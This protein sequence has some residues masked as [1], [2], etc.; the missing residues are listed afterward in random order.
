METKT[1]IKVFLSGPSDVLEDKNFIKSFIND[2]SQNDIGYQ[3]IDQGD[4]PSHINGLPAQ[5][6]I[7]SYLDEQKIDIYIG[8]MGTKFGT[9]TKE[10]GSGT[11]E[12]FTIFFE[13]YQRTN[14]PYLAFM[15]KETKVSIDDDVEAFLN[16]KNF[17]KKIENIGLYQKYENSSDLKKCIDKTLSEFIKKIKSSNKYS[18]QQS[19]SHE[20]ENID[21]PPKLKESFVTDCLD[22][23]GLALSNGIT[24]II[25]LSDIYIK[26]MLVRETAKKIP[27]GEVEKIE[28]PLEFIDNLADLPPYTIYVGGEGAGKTTILKKYFFPL[29]RMEKFQYFLIVKKKYLQVNFIIYQ[30]S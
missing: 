11:E 13:Q 24:K 3:V 19:S 7:N 29:L 6:T 25:S 17:R 22:H 18:E 16:V 26:P 10:F 23:P 20:I 14:T 1:I 4:F 5:E 2:L 21:I 28:K 8:L 9:P 15:F 12:E 27:K 30:D